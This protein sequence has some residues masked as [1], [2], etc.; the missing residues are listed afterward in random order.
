MN[1]RNLLKVGIIGTATATLC[2]FTPIPVI[3]LGVVGLSARVGWL[4]VVLCPPSRCSPGSRF[5]RFGEGNGRH[6]GA[7]ID[8]HLP[9][10][11]APAD[12]DHAHGRLPV[13]L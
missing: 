8:H 4:D 7:A 5:T 10:L 1:D 6:D 2:C 3:L 11:R 9:G 13:L 12:R